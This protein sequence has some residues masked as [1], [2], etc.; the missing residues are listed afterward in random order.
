[1]GYYYYKE[2]PKQFTKYLPQFHADSTVQL[3][4]PGFQ[5]H[6]LALWII[7]VDCCTLVMVA[8]NLRQVHSQVVTQLTEFSL[9]GVLEAELESYKHNCKIY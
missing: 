4:K 1:M 7:K 6:R 5:M 9:P 2:K 3:N 8:L